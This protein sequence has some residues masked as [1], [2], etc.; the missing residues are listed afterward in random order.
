MTIKLNRVQ[1]M[2]HP[3]SANR[4][5]EGSLHMSKVAGTFVFTGS[6]SKSPNNQC[7]IDSIPRAEPLNE[8]PQVMPLY[9]CCGMYNSHSAGGHIILIRREDG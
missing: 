3:G 2:Y 7:I 5:E 1:Y 4:Q 6:R 9:C 8:N